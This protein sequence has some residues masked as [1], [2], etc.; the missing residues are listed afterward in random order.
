MASVVGADV[1]MVS[2]VGA[3][4]RVLEKKVAEEPSL[5]V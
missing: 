3:E 4:R 2:V 1:V 5:E